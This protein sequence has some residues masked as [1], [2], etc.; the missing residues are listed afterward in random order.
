MTDRT[1]HTAPDIASHA[2]RVLK[3]DDAQLL[4]LAANN[5]EILRRIAASAL[6]QA[7]NRGEDE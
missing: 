1:E 3:M 6:T 4:V 5:P 7:R 2:A